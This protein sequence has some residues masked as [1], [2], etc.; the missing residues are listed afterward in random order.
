M[1]KHMAAGVAG[2]A[3]ALSP[4]IP[5]FA[6]Q[7]SA[8][9]ES[10]VQIPQRNEWSG[11]FPSFSQCA[12]AGRDYVRNNGAIGYTC[13]KIVGESWDLWVQ[14]IDDPST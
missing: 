13:K 8:Q 7:S 12:Q 3:L 4:A 11:R 1:A 2:L 14:Y 5:V 10:A 9:S 6:E